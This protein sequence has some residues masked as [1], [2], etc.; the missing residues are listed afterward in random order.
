MFRYIKT[1]T[2]SNITLAWMLDRVQPFL[3]LKW[4]QVEMEL[5]QTQA[6]ADIQRGSGAIWKRNCFWEF[7][8]R[9]KIRTPGQYHHNNEDTF[10]CIHPSVYFRQKG[11]SDSQ[12][13]KDQYNPEA[14]SGRKRQ[15]HGDQGA[16]MWCS[17]DTHNNLPEF[18]RGRLHRSAENKLVEIRSNP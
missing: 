16:I 8:F 10:E 5:R 12:D 14:L 11:I 2:L 9:E 6:L 3:A 17:P 18:H 1:N 7:L 13:G 4:D 15:V